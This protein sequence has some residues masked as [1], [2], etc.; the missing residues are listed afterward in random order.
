M[1]NINYQSTI[2]KNAMLT[3][4]T[5]KQ[6]KQKFTS[7]PHPF[8]SEPF[9][10]LNSWKVDRIVRLVPDNDKVSIGLVAGI[11]KG[12]LLA[13]FSAPFGGFHYRNERIYISEIESFLDQLK[14]YAKANKLNRIFIS[15]P[16]SI[17]QKSF[18]AK[19]VNTLIRLGYKMSLPEITCWVD[20]NEFQDRFTYKMSRQNYN[21]A[22]RNRLTFNILNSKEEKKTAFD[23]IL[24]NR[25]LFGRPIYMS[26]DEVLQTNE[27]WPINFFG[28]NNSEGQMVASA[29]FYPYTKD[30]VYGVFWGDNEIGR[31]LKSMDFLSFNLWS[32][33]KS[34]DYKYI[35]LSTAT[36][37][38][39]PNETLL[40]FKEIHECTSSIRYSFSYKTT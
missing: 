24:E 16:P 7:D 17:Y 39:I 2:K 15:L 11:K 25:A 4:V 19:V 13:P 30:I 34:L 23:L 36:E 40:R 37:C 32:Y 29:I 18:D 35:D 14:E 26:L 5:A 6:Y 9:I 27:L 20:L 8:I 10:E 22:I 38:G 28:I 31:R 1:Q 3:E 12:M 21:T 33:Y